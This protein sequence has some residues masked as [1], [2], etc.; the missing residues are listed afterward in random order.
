MDTQE[1]AA[2]LAEHLWQDTIHQYETIDPKASL[3]KWSAMRAER[4][5]AAILAMEGLI[6]DII[7]G[8]YRTNQPD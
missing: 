6:E 5:K 4:K 1:L 2:I 7:N 3:I 8:K